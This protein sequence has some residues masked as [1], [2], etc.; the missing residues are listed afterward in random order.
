MKDNDNDV[1]GLKK[2]FLLA[3]ASSPEEVKKTHYS[4]R[5]G[6]ETPFVCIA[7]ICYM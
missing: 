2:F 3:K 6:V 1:A 5:T 4:R 7:H